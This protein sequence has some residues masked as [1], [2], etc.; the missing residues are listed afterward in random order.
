MNLSS[1]T[2]RL[3]LW[4]KCVD[5]HGVIELLLYCLYTVSMELVAAV[6][7]FG[8]PVSPVQLVFKQSQGK[9]VRKACNNE[10]QSYLQL[11]I[12]LIQHSFQFHLSW[13]FAHLHVQYSSGQ[14]KLIICFCGTSEHHVEERLFI[15][16]LNF[17]NKNDVMTIFQ[18]NFRLSL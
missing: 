2:K 6:N 11:K 9:R 16:F 1:C 14:P 3:P 18:E 12:F 7:A 17:A 4:V 8:V 10:T 5:V 13:K 15:F